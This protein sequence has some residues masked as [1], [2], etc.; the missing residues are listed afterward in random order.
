M[1]ITKVTGGLLG[2]YTVG[3]NNVVIGDT[4]FDSVTTASNNTIIGNAAG[5]AIT[6]SKL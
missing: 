6:E 5:T 3:N 4:A 2:N 1:A